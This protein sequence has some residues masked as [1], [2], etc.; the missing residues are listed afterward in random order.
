M[1]KA[2][3]STLGAVLR[4]FR[5]ASG[6]TDEELARA[7]E[8][9]PALISAYERGRKP[10]SRERLEG[11]LA[12]MAVPPEA[13]EAALLAHSLAFPPEDQEGSSPVDP[14]PAE[15]R[16]VHEA[17]AVAGLKAA[18]ATRQ[19]LTAN[20]RQRRTTRA[21]RQAEARWKTLAVMT[22]E[23]RRSAV[24]KESRYW[25]WALAERLC[26]ESVRAAAHRADRAMEL[27]G[28][29]LRVAELSPESE[30]FRSRLQGYAWAFVANARRVQG[31][32]PGAEAAFARSDNLWAAVGEAAPSHLLD[33]SRRLDLKASLRCYQGRLQDALSLLDEALSANGSAETRVSV[34]IQKAI[35]L[36]LME[37]H[38]QAISVLQQAENLVGAMRSPRSI[39]LIRFTLASNLKQLHRYA[40][41]EALLPI[42]RKLAEGL[43]NELDSIRV[44]WLEGGVSAEL[45]KREQA[46]AALE[47]VRRY[48]SH[49]HIAYDA[50]LVSMELAVL[51]LELGQTTEV[52]RLAAGMLWIFDAQGVHQE[53]LAALRLFYEAVHRKEATAGLAR[54]VAGF[55]VKARNRPDLRFEA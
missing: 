27:A 46:L 23:G 36:E 15:R 49:H 33:G 39:F 28:L 6:W 51:Y 2:R 43:G 38:Q 19:K 9:Q 41:V 11:L 50:A 24:E 13:I 7:L 25:T 45:G 55:L 10:L 44:R 52:K 22:P 37:Q 12:V 31:D 18:E 40:E 30:A 35:T 26:N 32:L 21:R 53:A 14:S 16:T 29:A 3:P 54:R 34:L 42:V 17:A 5:F 1:P 20:L 8:I 48:F 4:F 47:E